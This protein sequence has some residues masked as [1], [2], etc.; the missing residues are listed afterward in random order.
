[1]IIKG[2]KKEK[3]LLLLFALSLFV[4]TVIGVHSL[5]VAYYNSVQHS[6]ESVLSQVQFVEFM[7]V[8]IQA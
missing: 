6:V 2:T 5:R 4:L 8:D 7:P 1:M 3:I